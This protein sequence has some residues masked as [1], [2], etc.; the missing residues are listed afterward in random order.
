MG[1]LLIYYMFS[2]LIGL[3]VMSLVLSLI[4]YVAS[5]LTIKESQ[6]ESKPKGTR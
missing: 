4:Q 2:L 5:T 3:I 1:T 6:R